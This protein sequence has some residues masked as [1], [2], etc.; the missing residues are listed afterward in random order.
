MEN[1]SLT[2]ETHPNNIEVDYIDDKIVR[3]KIHSDMALKIEMDN[4]VMLES[5][6]DF[7]I[8]SEGELSLISLGQPV[9]ID[10]I[11]SVIHLNS[12]ESKPI[13]DLPES[14]E[15]KKKQIENNKQCVQIATMQEMQNKT[16]KERVSIVENKLDEIGS[17]LKDFVKQIGG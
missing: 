17:I 11:N 7:S 8:I 2:I 3:I 15:Y 13:K 10:S 9:C 6:G 4:D 14:I 12:R 1:K 5:K 16:L